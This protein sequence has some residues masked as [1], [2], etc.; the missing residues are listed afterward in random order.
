MF[1]HFRNNGKTLYHINTSVI[2]NNKYWICPEI[3]SL[4]LSRNFGARNGPPR[5]TFYIWRTLGNKVG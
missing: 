5:Y 3:C 4:V 1:M 2:I